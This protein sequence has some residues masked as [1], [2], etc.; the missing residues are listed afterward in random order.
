MIACLL[1]LAVGGF[2]IRT[3][4][5][6]CAT[7]VITNGNP[8]ALPNGAGGAGSNGAAGAPGCPGCPGGAGGAGA[9]TGAGGA[10][11]VGGAGGQ[12][13]G[14]NTFLFISTW[15]FLM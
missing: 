14:G 13:L 10:G 3:A 15:L 1:L 6:V 7:C 4:D 8:G 5:A 9:G 11:G 12:G 2:Y